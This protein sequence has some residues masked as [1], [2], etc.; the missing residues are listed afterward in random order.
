MSKAIILKKL[1]QLKTLLGA[2]EPLLQEPLPQFITNLVKVR[3]AERNFELL[4]EV[5]SDINT[6]IL[7]D[8]GEKTPDSYKDSFLILQ[9]KGMLS[10]ALA[11]RLIESAKLCNILVHEYDFEEDYERFYHSAKQSMPAYREYFKVI[12]ASL[13]KD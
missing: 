4:V 1:E 13:P 12:H 7:L 8:K 9:E 5:A 6:Q 2:L 11:S 10:N 3:A